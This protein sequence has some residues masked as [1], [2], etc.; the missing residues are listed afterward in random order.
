MCA[1]A[2]GQLTVQTGSSN[3]SLVNSVLLGPGVLATNIKFNG[4]PLA[5]GS[6]NYSGPSSV[7]PFSSGLLL[8]T[9]LVTDAVGPNN[10]TKASFSHN[11]PSDSNLDALLSTP[12]NAYDAAVLEFDFYPST[13]SLT[14]SYVFASE[15]YPEFVNQEY[16]D[17]FGFFISGPSINGT[18]NLALIPGT[19]TPVSVN[20]IHPQSNAALY[21]DN[22]N[23]IQL[24]YDGLTKEIT[25]TIN[26]LQACKAYHI[27]LAIQDVH[28]FSYDSAIFLKGGSFSSGTLAAPAIVA[29]VAGNG[30]YFTEGCNKAGF[31]FTR[32]GDLSQALKLNFNLSGTA[33]LGTDYHIVKGNN[34]TSITIPAGKTT[35][36][37]FLTC[38]KDNINEQAESIVI[39]L[40]NSAACF[41][42]NTVLYIADLEDLQAEIDPPACAD[43]LWNLRM[44]GDGGSGAYDCH[45]Y[46]PSGTI[47]HNCFQPVKATATD[48]IFYCTLTDKCTGEAIHDTIVLKPVRSISLNTFFK[49][50]LVC[51]G[52]QIKLQG[53]AASPNPP[54][55]QPLTYLW[56]PSVGLDDPF[57]LTPTLTVTQDRT[58]TFTV[59]ND[60]F[61]THNAFVNVKV[62]KANAGQD[63][64]AICIY[65]QT[66]LIGKGGHKYHWEPNIAIDNT[67]IFNPTVNPTAM[68]PYELTIQD[69]VR[70]CTAKDTIVV[71]VD[72]PISA[73][74]GKD[75]IICRRSNVQLHSP[76]GD[77]Y[78]W[79]PASSLDNPKKQHPIANPLETTHYSLELFNGACISRDT[80]Q[81]RV[82][83]RPA[84]KF[85]LALDS[86]SRLV[87]LENL[88]EQT[89]DRYEWAFGDG[90]SAFVEQPV[91]HNYV[92][93]GIYTIRMVANPNAPLCSDTVSQV[94]DLQDPDPNKATVPNVFTPN[95]D[96]MNET[97]T[98]VGGK[99]ICLAEKMFIYNRWG[100]KLYT[101]TD[102]E[103][104]YWDGTINGSPAPEDVYY[105]VVQGQGYY[106]GGNLTLIR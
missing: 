88:S 9:G 103:H 52:T 24:Q 35:D 64:V 54:P 36:T 13:S 102:K 79:S 8:S 37:L 85:E 48:T 75:L 34:T 2:F 66:Q 11:K 39:S 1:T 60:E 45:W 42:P 49:D 27:K 56:L 71:R 94:V 69:T 78:K 92:Q 43:S 14:F 17:V 70:Q 83:D 4:G 46:T 12:D 47:S 21:I 51:K 106:K 68:Q 44:R 89:L 26:N 95:G 25:V 96:G 98:V 30:T 74:T 72:I 90:D 33:I 99:S 18:P 57:S 61:C 100:K 73:Y 16:N 7:L 20:S 5:I 40:L 86:C 65:G 53:Q 93:Q 31:V 76:K 38:V 87:G 82:I 55:L 97:F 6:F 105:Y 15:E 32:S 91:M 3:S 101:T 23:G 58:Y 29:Y 19:T 81:V 50:T 80:I 28:D 62:V 63:T 67:E 84:A 22:T 77:G 41:N 59:T 104:F 10:D